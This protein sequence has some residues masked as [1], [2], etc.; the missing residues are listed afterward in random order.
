MNKRNK[1]ILK[2]TLLGGLATTTLITLPIIW[3]FPKENKISNKNNKIDLSNKNIRKKTYDFEETMFVSKNQSLLFKNRTELESYVNKRISEIEVNNFADDIKLNKMNSDSVGFLTDSELENFDFTNSKLENITIYKGKDNIPYETEEEAKRSYFNLQEFIKVGNF[4]APSKEDLYNYL[5]LKE[6]ESKNGKKIID[7]FLESCQEMLNNQATSVSF[8]K[9]PEKALTSIIVEQLKKEKDKDK[10]KEILK[11]FIEN[12]QQK[13]VAYFDSDAKKYKVKTIDQYLNDNKTLDNIIK[14]SYVKLYSTRGQNKFIVDNSKEDKFD[15][16]GS[17]TLSSSSNY[18]YEITNKDNWSKSESPTGDL[19]RRNIKTQHASNIVSNLFSYILSVEISSNDKLT[20]EQKKEEQEKINPLIE[21]YD[22]KGLK[23]PFKETMKKYT[24]DKEELR[25]DLYTYLVDVYQR[26]NKGK[27]SNFLLNMYV[28]YVSGLSNLME[29]KA[30]QDHIIIY[31]EHFRR[32]FNE[33]SKTF[34]TFLPDVFEHKGLKT[35]NFSNINTKK[36]NLYEKWNIFD[37]DFDLS[38]D[39]FKLVNPIVE[40]KLAFNSLNVLLSAIMNS[41]ELY[42]KAEFNE[43]T[44]LIEKNNINE[45]ERN[46]YKRIFN[47]YSFKSVDSYFK[48]QNLKIQKNNNNFCPN[49]NLVKSLNALAKFSENTCKNLEKIYLGF[50]ESK[51]ESTGIKD[52]KLIV[53]I[54]NLYNKQKN[55]SNANDFINFFIDFDLTHEKLNKHKKNEFIQITR[56]KVKKIRSVSSLITITSSLK[57]IVATSIEG[58]NSIDLARNIVSSIR[59][60]TNALLDL[61]V[62]PES[63]L[64]KM[65]FDLTINVILEFIGTNI[66]FN[67]EYTVEKGEGLEKYIWNGGQSVSRLWGLWVEESSTI[68]DAK[69]IRP[70]KYLNAQE[71]D[72]YYFNG[73]KYSEIE[74]DKLKKDIINYYKHNNLSLLISQ[75]I[76]AFNTW[77]KNTEDIENIINE[78]VGKEKKLTS[79]EL[80]KITKNKAW[81]DVDEIVN[82]WAQKEFD[83]NN[84]EDWVGKLYYVNKGDSIWIPSKTDTDFTKSLLKLIDKFKNN[85]YS[86]IP[87]LKKDNNYVS[88]PIDQLEKDNKEIYNKTFLDKIINSENADLLFSDKEINELTKFNILFYAEEF[89]V[90]NNLTFWKENEDLINKFYTSFN[91]KSKKVSYL[92]YLMKKKYD[93]MKK[94]EKKYLYKFVNNGREYYFLN[95]DKARQYI[96]N[97]F[98]QIKSNKYLLKS[99]TY[100]Y[101]DNKEFQSIL[102]LNKYII[103]KRGEK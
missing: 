33:I 89:K 95:K 38:T 44:D 61:W 102:E 49:N 97:S 12:N 60:I 64:I 69:F 79:S 5:M 101:Y 1:K 56:P 10:A 86:S 24:V 29:L 50:K 82:H 8:L 3:S 51:W 87:I 15:L 85:Y 42:S 4:I 54:K 7:I 99:K 65:V 30:T 96:I 81:I 41:Q 91:V 39:I 76:I 71:K 90:K 11:E 43:T 47:Y 34:A 32:I 73:S 59:D 17:Y 67:Y 70:I 88:Y 57:N 36:V 31:K 80:S 53:D 62:T 52:G 21:T 98:L 68:K 74:I 100:Y 84:D 13:M 103:K 23:N 27:K 18:I 55:C 75:N 25:G 58:G 35:K 28:L 22:N 6:N 78:S 2:W 26:L 14:N 72:E 92:S 37:G 46:Y 45:E 20:D 40:N 66:N 77:T 48:F 9:T 83:F 63:M 16:F 94:I 19:L 93:D